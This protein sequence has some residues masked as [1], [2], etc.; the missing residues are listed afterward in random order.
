MPPRYD[1][2]LASIA[3]VAGWVWLGHSGSWL[4]LAGM[5]VALAVFI[6]AHADA[7]ALLRPT[8]TSVLTG[9]GCAAAMILATYALYSIAASFFPG[10][11]PE[12]A[13]L[14]GVLGVGK[15]DT[16]GPI[17]LI[18][19]VCA[20]EEIIFRGR[21]FGPAGGG[22]LYWPHRSDWTRILIVTTVYAAVHLPSRSVTLVSVA[23]ACGIAWSIVRVVT[24]SV[25]APILIHALWDLCVMIFFPVR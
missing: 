12:M 24:R 2:L 8:R 7:R 19:A 25:V 21:V 17:L 10:L 5:G 11:A 18:L 16:P 14:Y 3:W 15:E 13:R 9:V 6:L 20:S 1:L 4:P 22:R 23:F